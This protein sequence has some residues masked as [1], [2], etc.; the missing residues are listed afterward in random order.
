ML[1]M[2]ACRGRI[3]RNPFVESDDDR[4]RSGDTLSRILNSDPM[5]ALLRVLVLL[6]AADLA[7]GATLALSGG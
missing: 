2:R 3:S 1:A 5:R 6:F 7:L 4:F